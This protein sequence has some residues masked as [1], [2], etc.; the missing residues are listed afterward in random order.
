MKTVLSL[1]TAFFLL[2]SGTPS[3]SAAEIGQRISIAFFNP[4][5]E[6]SP[7]WSQT[8]R[9]MQAA[10]EDLNIQLEVY[11]GNNDPDR[12][13]GLVSQRLSR[14]DR[15][16]F[17]IFK[18]NRDAGVEILNIAESTG[19]F[20]V[21]IHTTLAPIQRKKL[22]GP[23]QS[24]RRWIAE[25]TIGREKAAA[26][27][28]AKLFSEAQRRNLVRQGNA[29]ELKLVLG[30][31]RDTESIDIL[32]GARYAA[33]KNSRGT[34]STIVHTNG[35]RKHAR[36]GIQKAYEKFGPKRLYIAHGTESAAGILDIHKR[37]RLQPGVDVVIGAFEWS[38]YTL[39][40]LV[41]NRISLL[42]GGG[43]LEGA[44]AL[45]LIRDFANGR[46][47][48]SEGIRFET[49]VGMLTPESGKRYGPALIHGNWR[50]IDFAQFTKTA[51]PTRQ[52]YDLSIN[53]YLKA[54]V[55]A[56]Q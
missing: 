11:Y 2:T 35:T 42:L 47:F 53:S 17:I 40:Q 25:M 3:A 12:L 18:A 26:Q 43:F 9:L 39:G 54:L 27:L 33:A 41:Q 44:S 16:Q 36:K 14:A 22:G 23:R 45:V 5:T 4:A 34:V 38:H 15:P 28:A 10:A 1:I 48:A 56:Q 52:K 46:D 21:I 31:K 55:A 7:Y 24:F 30:D 6:K 29:W 51:N 8:T 20:S 50:A 32:T 19:T 13:I 49:R 37:S